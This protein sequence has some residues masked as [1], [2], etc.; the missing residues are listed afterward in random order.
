VLLATVLIGLVAVS[1]YLLSN[2]KLGQAAEGECPSFA[3]TI[4]Q[5]GVDSR[6]IERT[7]AMPLENELA[8]IAGVRDLRSVS[9][10]GKAKATI[11]MESGADRGSIYLQVRDAADRVYSALPSS[12]QKPQI[13]S[14]SSSQRPVFAV[15]LRAAGLG[16][17]A[18]RELV[19]KEIKPSFEKVSGVGEIEVG[20]GSVQEVHV[21]VDSAK[22]AE[23]GLSISSVAEQIQRQDFTGPAGPVR[24]GSLELPVSLHG[25]IASLDELAKLS[26]TAGKSTLRLG[27]VAVVSYAGRESDSVSRVDGEKMI[28]LYAQSAGSANLVALSKALRAEAGRWKSRG[29]AVDVILDSGANLERALVRIARAMVEGIVAVLVILPVAVPDFKKLGALSLTIVLVPMIAAAALSALGI[30]IDEFVLSG[31][32]VGLG[33]IV[34]NGAIVVGLRDLRSLSPLFPSLRSSLLTILIVLVPLFFLDFVA[35]GIARISQSMA[36]LFLIAFALTLFFLPAFTLVRCGGSPKP[37]ALPRGRRR[38][39]ARLALRMVYRAIRASGKRP[40]PFLAASLLVVAALA[41]SIAAM[42]RDFSPSIEEDAVYAHIEFESGASIALVDERTAAFAAAARKIVGATMVETIARRGGADLTLKFDPALAT[43]LA[44]ESQTRKLGENIPGGF[45]YFPEGTDK[46]RS[47][48]IAVLGEDDAVLRSAAGDAARLFGEAGWAGQVVLNFKNPPEALV[49]ELDHGKA[50]SLGVSAADAANALRWALYGPVALKWVEKDRER[51]LRVF[52]DSARTLTRK[53]LLGMPMLS[54]SGEKLRISGI[55]RLEERPEGAKIYRKNRQ[56]AAFLTVHAGGASVDETVG[57]IKETLARIS[58]PPGYAFEMDRSVLELKRGFSAL[59]L[60]LGL[61]VFLIYIVLASSMESLVCPFMVL[62][63]LPTS[64]AFP[65]MALFASGQM[66]KIPMLVGL[67]MLC[68]MAV[69][70]SI[71]IANEIRSRGGNRRLCARDMRPLVAMAIRKRLRPLL[72]S[73]VM[74]VVGTLPLLFAG[75][76]DGEFMRSISFVVFWGIPG[77]LASTFLLLPAL[78]C[79]F[80]GAFRVLSFENS[81]R[82]PE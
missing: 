13:A 42:G 9:E 15:S 35:P 27:D 80:P 5:F 2:A 3:V 51:D 64:L 14:S 28:V 69:N 81:Q 1:A 22:A 54:G 73:S 55:S 19:D 7:I 65:I 12:A 77:S 53:G 18:F 29:V 45:V 48:E 78:A 56:R 16:E 49:L 82:S 59:F 58:L 44:I 33:T 25:R 34:D 10:Y 50:A 62:S 70:N 6:E 26:L 52:S 24:V 47:Y 32:A 30:G 11:T 39:S 23:R 61:S 72:V 66:L 17:E 79:A 41:A 68:G 20:G 75:G 74:T 38:H 21:L 67:I 71:L 37:A 63:I 40:A 46:K 43:R 31:L 57:R 76:S 8:R 36:I 60:A 4:E